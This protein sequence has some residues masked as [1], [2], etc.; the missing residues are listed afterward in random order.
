METVRLL[1]FILFLPG[2]TLILVLHTL[3]FFSKR[4]DIALH[5]FSQETRF[6]ATV[7]LLLFVF[8]LLGLVFALALHVLSL[9]AGRFD[10][11]LP[12]LLLG[13]GFYTTYFPA[14][15]KEDMLLSD[16]YGIERWKPKKRRWRDLHTTAAVAMPNIPAG[17][18]RGI[19]KAFYVGFWY[20][21]VLLGAAFIAVLFEM[22]VSQ[23][24]FPLAITAWLIAMY[25]YS[26]GIHYNT[27]AI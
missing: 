4:F 1:F 19:Y 9:F 14:V 6:M 18:G 13:A 5:V 21:V 12:I 27:H 20:A 26:T 16:Y 24:L 22:A 3:S 11:M 15:I 8:S 10:I 25:L 23:T 2:L 17:L 7:R